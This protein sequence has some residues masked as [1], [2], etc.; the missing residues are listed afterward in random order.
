MIIQNHDLVL[1]SRRES[2]THHEVSERLVAWQGDN[3]IDI[4]RGETESS[5]EIERDS[6]RSVMV[7][8]SEAAMNKFMTSI[9]KTNAGNVSSPAE[10]D[11]DAAMP[12]EL[13]YMKMVLEKFFGIKIKIV[14]PNSEESGEGK[15]GKA[16]ANTESAQPQEQG[17]G[18]EYS[19]HELRYE[20]EAVHF[21]AAGTVTTA[22][23]REIAFET[24]LEMSRETFEEMS[25]E[26]RAGD[27]LID[28]LALNLDGAG[29]RLTEEKYDFDLD[30]DGTEEKIS[31]LKQGS[32]FLVLDKNK[33]G[34]V[35]DG[36]ELFGPSTNN[37]FLELKAHDGDGNE[38]IDESD[39]IFYDL[40]L[41][42]KDAEGT[43]HLAGLK[44]HDIG[45]LYLGSS[46]TE[47]DLGEGQLRETGI[48]LNESGGTG[49]IQEVDLKAV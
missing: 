13:Q 11:E 41:W 43:D 5:G 38:W 46:G 45:A 49:F 48:Y 29:V 9:K 20:K 3:R 30:A 32:G 7:E 25:V 37:G 31:F 6:N 4:A 47:F 18:I 19:Y 44:A 39:A 21:S 40:K 8:I 17:W 28:P 27:A 35:D 26:F 24:Q 12:S 2:I 42:T 23:G 15:T 36:G 1:N 34:I 22:D 33:N 10:E 14:N 16:A